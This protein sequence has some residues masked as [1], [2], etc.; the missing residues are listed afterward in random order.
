[1]DLMDAGLFVMKMEIFMK[2][3]LKIIKK[4][5]EEFMYMQMALEMK[6]SS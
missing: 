5:E 6:E 3:N 2:V 1:M 4:K